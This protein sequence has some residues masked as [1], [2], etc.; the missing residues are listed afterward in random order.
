MKVIYLRNELKK[1]IST[2]QKELRDLE[3]TLWVTRGELSE[4]KLIVDN[5]DALEKVMPPDPNIILPL[6]V[7]GESK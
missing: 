1:M 3:I 5:W 6:E 2:K 4:L 7:Y